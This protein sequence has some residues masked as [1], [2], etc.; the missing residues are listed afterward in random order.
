MRSV[1][2]ECCESRKLWCFVSLFK[3]SFL[4]ECDVDL[5]VV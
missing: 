5:V 1:E 4:D 2:S 3:L